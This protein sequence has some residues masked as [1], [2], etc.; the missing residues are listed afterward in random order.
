MIR[1]V[2]EQEANFAT[3]PKT[4]QRVRLGE[5]KEKEGFSGFGSWILYG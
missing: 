3:F 2:E 4:K 1:P 5:G